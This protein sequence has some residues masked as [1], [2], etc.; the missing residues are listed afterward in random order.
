MQEECDIV[1]RN[2][3]LYQQVTIERQSASNDATHQR[4]K[5]KLGG[6]EGAHV[7]GEGDILSKI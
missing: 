7:V 3:I 4:C 5:L 1:F 6:V 2:T